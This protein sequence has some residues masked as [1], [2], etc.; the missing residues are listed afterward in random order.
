MEIS[1]ALDNIRDLKAPDLDGFGAKFFKS[2]WNII[3]KDVI[4]VVIEFFA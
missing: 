4:T 1:K 3:N 2:S